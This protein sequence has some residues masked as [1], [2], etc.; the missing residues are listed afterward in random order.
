MG[1]PRKVYQEGEGSKVCTVCDQTFSR[2]TQTDQQWQDKST[3]GYNCQRRAWRTEVRQLNATRQAADHGI[4]I[5]RTD[6]GTIRGHDPEPVP[7]H[8]A[9]RIWAHR[10]RGACV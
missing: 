5:D 6:Y 7:A 1:R 4:E 10:M 9:D 3:C 2:T 8:L